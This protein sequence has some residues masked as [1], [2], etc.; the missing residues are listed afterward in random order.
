MT[1][2]ISISTRRNENQSLADFHP[3]ALGNTYSFGALIREITRPSRESQVPSPDPCDSRDG[4]PPPRL[5][6]RQIS[7]QYSNEKR[8]FSVV[9]GKNISLSLIIACYPI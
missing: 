7:I 3:P 4:A 8:H 1:K 9:L 5:Q 2:G 6:I